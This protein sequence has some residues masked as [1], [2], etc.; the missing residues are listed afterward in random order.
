MS[1]N[2]QVYTYKDPLS[3]NSISFDDLNQAGLDGVWKR[4]TDNFKWHRRTPTFHDDP[5][6]SRIFPDLEGS[7]FSYRPPFVL[8][9]QNITLVG[10]RTF[11]DQRNHWFNDQAYLEHEYIQ[12]INKL[13]CF[14]DP[15]LNEWTGFRS[16]GIKGSFTMEDDN[17][18]QEILDG[19]TLVGCCVEPDNYGSWLFR[20]IPKLH[21]I[22]NLQLKFDRI[23][24][25]ARNK[26]LQS[27]FDLMDVDRSKFI[28]HDRNKIYHMNHA[29]IPSLQNSNGYL[30]D[31]TLKLYTNLRNCHGLPCFGEKIFIS[32]LNHVKKSHTTRVLQNEQELVKRLVKEGFKIVYPELLSIKAQIEVFSSAKLVVGPSGSAMFNVVFCHPG[33]KVI[34]IESEPHWIHAHLSL[35]SSLD[36]NFGI[37]VGKVDPTDERPVHK[38]WTVNIPALLDRIRAFDD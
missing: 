24:I 21:T 27:Y 8:G 29:I 22:L 33:T 6:Q 30:D 14:Q 38:R 34:D 5:D 13:I 15:F 26:G 35:F 31:E 9:H 10:Q 28:Q 4:Y 19:T 11:L 3:F 32:R 17:R 23:L 2:L 1:I 37:F 18:P 20:V 7:S 25:D 16:Q 36:L 12:D